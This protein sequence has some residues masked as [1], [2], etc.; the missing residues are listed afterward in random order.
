MVG[1]KII[2]IFLVFGLV[3]GCT[4]IPTQIIPEPS[5]A[6]AVPAV[7][8]AATASSEVPAIDASPPSSSFDRPQVSIASAP[9]G[10]GLEAHSEVRVSGTNMVSGSMTFEVLR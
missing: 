6:P 5:P 7:R 2:W 4:I 9:K 8:L 10:L 3:L 1:I